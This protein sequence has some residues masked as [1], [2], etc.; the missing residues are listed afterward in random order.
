VKAGKVV[1]TTVCAVLDE[2]SLT[3]VT[4]GSAVFEVSTVVP[5]AVVSTEITETGSEDAF[6]VV[7]ETVVAAELVAETVV[8]AD[9]VA[10]DVVAADVVAETVVAAE[11]GA[12]DVIVVAAADT[13]PAFRLAIVVATEEE[14]VANVSDVRPSADT[15]SALDN[16]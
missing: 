15:R 4:T 8:A 16:R 6:S 9:V 10:A 5:E 1:A 2:L 3:V 12:S 14:A 13:S 11:L 7:A